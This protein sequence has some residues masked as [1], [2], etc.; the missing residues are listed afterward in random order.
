MAADTQVSITIAMDMRSMI[1]DV[2]IVSDFS[3][4]PVVLI[5]RV[6]SPLLLASRMTKVPSIMTIPY[7]LSSIDNVPDR[8]TSSN[9]FARI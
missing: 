6:R 4:K 9:W 2:S 8:S 3:A 5:E 7:V 1:A